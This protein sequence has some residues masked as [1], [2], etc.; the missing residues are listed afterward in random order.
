MNLEQLQKSYI[1]LEP[2]SIYSLNI[3][4]LLSYVIFLER[5]KIIPTPLPF[6]SPY[7]A[8]LATP[9]YRQILCDFIK[10]S[11]SRCFQGV[12]FLSFSMFRIVF[13]LFFFWNSFEMLEHLLPATFLN[14][15]G[16][17]YILLSVTRWQSYLHAIFDPSKP[18]WRTRNV[19][20]RT[21]YTYYCTVILIPRPYPT[22]VFADFMK[23]RTRK[24]PTC[25]INKTTNKCYRENGRKTTAWRIVNYRPS[26]FSTRNVCGRIFGFNLNSAF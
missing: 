3:F 23:N 9:R 5:S 10:Q 25:V 19:L 16:F 22:L 1:L 2:F 8:L 11:L 17:S 12:S 21:G 18:T 24:I 4:G 6:A 20:P 14:L 13:W 26:I 7:P 15:S